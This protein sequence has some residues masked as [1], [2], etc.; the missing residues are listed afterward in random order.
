M[1]F[2]KDKGTDLVAQ[3]D[4]SV[5]ESIEESPRSGN[6]RPL[7]RLQATMDEANRPDAFFES[8]RVA[9]RR[10]PQLVQWTTKPLWLLISR[11]FRLE[12]RHHI[13]RFTVT[14]EFHAWNRNESFLVRY[15]AR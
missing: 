14:L 13:V 5:T 9:V 2:V 7:F 6:V 10:V 12:L 11:S 4:V 15:S 3:V 1:G 8:H